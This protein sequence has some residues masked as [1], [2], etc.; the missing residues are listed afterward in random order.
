LQDEDDIR[1]T[2]PLA[3][4]PSC[5]QRSSLRCRYRC[6][7]RPAPR[8]RS[9][10]EGQPKIE[11]VTLA[12]TNGRGNAGGCRESR[13][14]EEGNRRGRS[15]LAALWT[16]ISGLTCSSFHL[17]ISVGF[18][19]A[20]YFTSPWASEL[21]IAESLVSNRHDPL[22]IE[23]LYF[24]ITYLPRILCALQQGWLC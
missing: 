19:Q 11:W 24:A 15:K 23:P 1:I 6:P 8:T 3:P 2:V 17:A 5:R 18:S 14:G 16:M 21:Q 4:P 20:L 22:F 13:A 7:S 9:A 10:G 12:R